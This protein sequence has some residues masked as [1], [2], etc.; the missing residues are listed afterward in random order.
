M[1]DNC[2]DLSQLNISNIA[3]LIPQ[4][5]FNIYNN[6]FDSF[7]LP[8]NQQ[9]FSFLD[10][11]YFDKSF[12]KDEEY[13]KKKE[14]ECLNKKSDELK[15][16]KEDSIEN[17]QS[18]ICDENFYHH[19]S[20]GSTDKK[21]W[22][23][24]NIFLDKELGSPI[25]QPSLKF[26]EFFEKME[27]LFEEDNMNIPSDERFPKEKAKKKN[28]EFF[29]GD[30]GRKNKIDIPK[31]PINSKLFCKNS[32]NC[33][34]PNDKEVKIHIPQKT[35]NSNQINQNSNIPGFHNKSEIK[36]DTPQK[37]INSKQTDKNSTNNSSTGDS[38]QQ[39]NPNI[40]IINKFK[41]PFAIIHPQDNIIS[42]NMKL[43]MSSANLYSN[44]KRKRK[45]V[46]E[47]VKKHEPIKKAEDLEKL[48]LR[49][50]KGYLRDNKK[51]K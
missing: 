26:V 9:N 38:S 36:I 19:P 45:R 17:N 27:K 7:E 4:Y 12:E 11:V 34:I 16:N 35:V 32:S 15:Y 39:N 25:E 24:S 22:E 50:F 30:N 49:K 37:S 3:P 51:K 41:Y 44:F 48:I 23:Y 28:S 14:E 8:S 18:Q 40:S 29:S 47:E 1:E 2:P 5:P 13:N 43:N 31:N 6:F 42:S 20:E 46:R 21:D 33:P 10:R